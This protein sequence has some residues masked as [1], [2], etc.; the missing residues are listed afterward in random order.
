MV[1]GNLSQSDH[2]MGPQEFLVAQLCW[3]YYPWTSSIFVWFCAYVV[4]SCCLPCLSRINSILLIILWNIQ[5]M[6][7]HRVISDFWDPMDHSP[8]SSSVHGIIYVRTLKWIA[9]SSS[10][11]SCRPR[12]GTPSPEVPA[13]TGCSLALSYLGSLKHTVATFY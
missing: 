10:R 3:S 11:G 5:G 8:P 13:L 2:I 9:I 1:V 12:G 4:L 7:S 6:L